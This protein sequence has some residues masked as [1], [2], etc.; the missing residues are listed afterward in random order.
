MNSNDIR[1]WENAVDK[2]EE[3][4]LTANLP[5]PEDFPAGFTAPDQGSDGVHRK[6][7]RVD[8]VAGSAGA[9]WAYWQYWNDPKTKQRGIGPHP[10][11]Q[12]IADSL[13]N[14][15]AP[16]F[17]GMLGVPYVGKYGPKAAWVLI[18]PHVT[19]APTARIFEEKQAERYE[20]SREIY[21]VETGESKKI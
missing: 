16:H 15:D 1:A 19:P 10:E 9:R 3:T 11:H 18:E 12:A 13:F 7:L 20:K 8:I 5:K 21:D 4:L 2:S 14:G 6:W 17:I